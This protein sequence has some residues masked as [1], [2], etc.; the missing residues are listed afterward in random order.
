M[1]DKRTARKNR[2]INKKQAFGS[3]YSNSLL[4]NQKIYKQ[5]EKQQHHHTISM[6]QTETIELP[7]EIK[8]G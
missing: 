5:N 8:C 3:I 6:E 7:L 1:Q 4:T 2:N